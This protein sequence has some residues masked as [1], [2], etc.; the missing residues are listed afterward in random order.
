[1]RGSKK[2]WRWWKWWGFGGCRKPRFD[3][4]IWWPEWLLALLM[5]VTQHGCGVASPPVTGT[6]A[7]LFCDESVTPAE[8]VVVESRLESGY[9]GVD[10]YEHT[11]C[12]MDWAGPGPLGDRRIRF[13]DGSHEVSP[14]GVAFVPDGY[15]EV[16]TTMYPPGPDRARQIAGT[17]CHEF[18]HLLGLNH[19]TAIDWLYW[20]PAWSGMWCTP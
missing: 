18:A 13:L 19:V 3:G 7:L 12:G 14:Y 2:G 8:R 10:F 5:L 4:P 17:A 1:M 9:P 16:Y 11:S 15:A 6:C 20:A